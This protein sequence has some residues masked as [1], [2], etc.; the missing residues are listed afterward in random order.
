MLPILPALAA[1]SDDT[2]FGALHR[3]LGVQRK[4]LAP[5]L[6]EHDFLGILTVEPIDD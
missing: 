3:I 2:D 5:E 4:D 1:R 6:L